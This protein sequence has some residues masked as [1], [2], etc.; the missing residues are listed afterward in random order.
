MSRKSV[1]AW[2]LQLL[3]AALFAVQGA[4]GYP[5][6]FY[7]VIGSAE[8]AGALLLVIPQLAKFGALLVIA[9][10]IGATATHVV[11]HEPQVRTTL[12]LTAAL[13]AVLYLRRAP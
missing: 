11:H 2:V 4:W 10:M 6:H 3:L 8:L 9:I 7:F 5:E 12:V 13:A 1:A